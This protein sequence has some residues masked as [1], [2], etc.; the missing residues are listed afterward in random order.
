M[1][2]KGSRL[3]W[4]LAV[5]CKTSLRRLMWAQTG[6][7][8]R[9]AKLDLQRPAVADRASPPAL[10]NS[11]RQRQGEHAPALELVRPSLVWPPAYRRAWPS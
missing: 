1:E 7:P 10:R 4:S 5:G 11:W 3:R 8:Q 2:R 6:P 9:W